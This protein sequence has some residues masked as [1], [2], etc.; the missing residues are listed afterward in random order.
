MAWADEVTLLC[1]FAL[2]FALL[3]LVFC[4]MYFFKSSHNRLNGSV[5]V[6]KVKVI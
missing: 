4:V 6:A 3:C 2:C 1:V 5:W